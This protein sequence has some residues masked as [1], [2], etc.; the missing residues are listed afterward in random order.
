VSEGG[1]RSPWFYVAIGCG[2]MLFVLLVALGLLA[3]FGMSWFKTVRDEMSDPAARES[4]A[5]KLLGAES[6]PEGYYAGAALSVPFVLDM[7]VLG[8]APPDP[9][10]KIPDDAQHE[11]IYMNMIRG[12][13]E[14]GEFIEGK[15][16]PFDVLDSGNFDVD[17]GESI[18][19]AELTVGEQRI[20]FISERGSVSTD[21]GQSEG[22][23]S[24]MFIRCDDKR[25]R[26]ALWTGPDPLPEVPAAEADFTGTS[27]DPE[28]AERFMGAFDTC[29]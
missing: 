8:D 24:L 18:A 16:D 12:G 13:R 19:Q 11:F 28:V 29:K 20:T 6:L 22:L 5:L 3:W 21:H 9:G 2:G 4:R 23:L 10:G 1:G 27:A 26:F 7:V 15:G 14:W 17:R 25:M